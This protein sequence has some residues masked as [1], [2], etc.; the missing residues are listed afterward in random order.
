MS[1]EISDA[2]RAMATDRQREYIDAINECG[3]LGRAA[4]KCGVAYQTIQNAIHRLNRRTANIAKQGAIVDAKTPK[5]RW[6]AKEKDA[7]WTFNGTSERINNLEDALAFSNVDLDVWEV[8]SHVFN[9]WPTTMKMPNGDVVQAANIQ[10]QIKFRR[11]IDH[12]INWTKTMAWVESALKKRPM[13]PAT[14]KKKSKRIGVA[15]NADMHLGAYSDDLL[16]AEK[17][18]IGILSQKL[19]AMVNSINSFGLDEV[20]LF[21]LGDNI[22]SFT[23]LNHRN[24]WKGLGKGAFGVRAVILVFEIIAERVFSRVKN[25]KS[26]NLVSGNHDRVSSEADLDPR[27]EATELLAYMLNREF[28]KLDVNFHPL[29][30]SR[31]ID[32]ISYVATHGHNGL[33]KQEVSKILFDHGKQGIYNVVM[34]GH[35]HCRTMRKESSSKPFKVDK[36]NVVSM[37]DANYRHVTVPPMFT[38]NFWSDSHG[39]AS[40]SGYNLFQNN[41]NGK[42]RF[43]DECV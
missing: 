28:S 39:W 37:D 16:R 22:E 13:N 21:N 7:E 3:T 36:M 35:Y 41:G 1:Y 33:S 15:A 8:D 26:I 30:I 24:S 38:G 23:G 12:D 6:T 2:V 29:L 32:G 34:Q 19:D 42:I 9:K 10:V 5:Q 31:E 11:K 43:F 25:L 40:A 27:G 14:S 4:K 20:H 18:N 17:F